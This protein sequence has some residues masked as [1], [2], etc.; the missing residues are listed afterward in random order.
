MELLKR[1]GVGIAMLLFVLAGLGI[2]QR[3]ALFS[4][5]DNYGELSRGADGPTG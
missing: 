5:I 3:K 2:W 1:L 4:V